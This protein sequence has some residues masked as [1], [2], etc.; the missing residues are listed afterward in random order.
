MP[1]LERAYGG[2]TNLPADIVDLRAQ[3]AAGSADVEARTVLERARGEFVELVG[4]AR[5]AHDDHLA[6]LVATADRAWQRHRRTEERAQSRCADAQRA[7]DLGADRAAREVN[8][9][10]DQAVGRAELSAKT[11]RHLIQAS[12][13]RARHR[14]A[15][16]ADA[17]GTQV[18][19]IVNRLAS[20]YTDLLGS[21]ANEITDAGARA[22]TAIRLFGDGSAALLPG[23]RDVVDEALN[24]A[25]R[26]EARHSATR[27]AARID[28]ERNAQ[29]TAYRNQIP[30]VRAQ[31]DQSEFGKALHAHKDAIRV[32]GGKTVDHAV[33]IALASLAGQVREARHSLGQMAQDAKGSL[34]AQRTAGRSRAETAART[35]QVTAREETRAELTG[36]ETACSTGLPAFDNLIAGLLRGL[37]R[38]GE[39][40][41]RSLGAAT[42]TG[43]ID[44]ARRIGELAANQEHTIGVSDLASEG[45]ISR[46]SGEGDLALDR[47]KQV[48]QDAFQQLLFRSAASIE[49]FASG[50]E[51]SFSRLA[52][53]VTLAAEKWAMP[54]AQYF[55][56]A[57]EQTRIQLA[58]ATG[59]GSYQTW[60]TQITEQKRQFL[61]HVL[62]PYLQP[63]IAFGPAMEAAATQVREDLQNRLGRLV[64]AFDYGVIDRVDES[65]ATGA[66]RGL[67]AIQGRAL[68]HLFDEQQQR[69]LGVVLAMKLDGDDLVAARAYLAGNTAA[70]AAAELRASIHWYNDEESRIESIMRS[71]T[72]DELAQ[73][74]RPGNGSEALDLVRDNLGGTDLNVFDALTAGNHDRADAY[75]MRDRIQDARRGA[76]IDA[77]H[78]VLADYSHVSD[79]RG[80]AEQTADERRLGVQRELAYVLGGGEAS[81][82]PSQTSA[83]E[84]T[85]AVEAFVLA[86]MVV[87]QPGGEG[88]AQTMTIEVSGANRDLA[89]ALI[90]EGE[91][92]ISARAARLGV[93][94]QRSGGPTMLN[95]DTALVNPRL[96]P[97]TPLP[98]EEREHARQERDQVF[99]QFARQYGGQDQAGTAAAARSFAEAQLR[100]A[101]GSDQ[102]S[103]D[104]AV[105]LAHDEHPTPA[106]AARAIRLASRGVGTDEDLMWR[107]VERMNRDEIQQM[108]REYRI[109]SGSSLDSDLGTFGGKGWFTELSGDDRLRMERA[110]LGQPR[111]DRERM[112]VATFAAQQQREETGWLGSS[113][114]SGSMQERALTDST[115]R[116]S[117]AVGGLQVRVDDQGNPVWTDQAGRRVDPGGTAFDERGGYGGSDRGA[118]L[119]AVQATSIAAEN[120]AA[121]VDSYANFLATTV[122]VIGAIAA[123]VATVATGGAASPLLMA[124]IAGVTGLTAMAV[125][126][127]VSG[128]RYGWEQAATD[129][130]M[131]AVQALTAGVGQHLAIV[132]RG[133]T[134]GLMVGMTTLRSAQGLA[135][136]M[137]AI[138]GSAL[139]DL[140]VVGGASGA[141]GAFGSAALSEAT[142][143]KGF[144]VGFERLIESTLTGAV[145]GAA[146]SAASSA[147]EA[148]PAGRGATGIRRTLGD[149]MGESSNPLVRGVLRG[150]ASAIGASNRSWSR[151]RHR[152]PD[153]A[154]QGRCRRHPDLDG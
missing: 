104:V 89:A 14:I 43:T 34:A 1:R 112:E 72:P 102:L 10:T 24:E 27:F 124:A 139:G 103:A 61:D 13:T 136:S 18:T 100:R 46:V 66:L 20:M 76:D 7:I 56:A 67:T 50:H 107:F 146:T 23:G 36:L 123:A 120:Y 93:E 98:L 87:V 85:A 2:P 140:L 38:A 73:L 149:V 3:A 99:Q 37:R 114:A 29:A 26:V 28:T 133:G 60:A 42:T 79:D 110:L 45:S 17:A 147:F 80:R 84:A 109:Q 69:D 143:S 115:G 49:E 126:A 144:G 47:E 9:A 88:E 52:T 97:N 125:R 11:A 141:M 25:R 91:G 142:W 118:F 4:R 57:V 134:Q 74:K 111:N 122:A 65:G 121:K 54:L 75:K 151:A 58:E 31:F 63:A 33:G 82:H 129:L 59:P 35:V 137:G 44:V 117:A 106:T 19:E 131:T 68:S 55:A 101:Y 81:G 12:A 21:T 152:S 119:S 39:G 51:S 135:Q 78:T 86:P 148:I 77:I 16:N 92:S 83:A 6:L 62:A 96:N 70:G 105:G 94:V 127:S 128:G 145:T 138:T 48:A 41:T 132:A 90:R 130:G 71:L 153:R 32:E 5:H 40:G 15:A 64:A 150:S 53:G 30:V 116:L 154:L 22:V 108:R 95:L 8:A 113:L